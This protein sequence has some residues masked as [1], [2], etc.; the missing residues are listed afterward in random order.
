MKKSYLYLASIAAITVVGIALVWYYNTPHYEQV[1]IARNPGAE[2]ESI[3]DI[4]SKRIDKNMEPLFPDTSI[5]RVVIVT[6]TNGSAIQNNIYPN[7]F[8][9]C[10]ENENNNIHPLGKD[11]NPAIV[12]I[13]DTKPTIISF[14]ASNIEQ[15]RE[16]YLL[17]LREADISDIFDSTSYDNN[18]QGLNFALNTRTIDIPASQ[19][20]NATYAYDREPFTIETINLNITATSEARLG[21]HFFYFDVIEPQRKESGGGFGTMGIPV[22]VEVRR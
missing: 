21:L 3:F 5:K 22:W 6:P 8:G 18:I 7:G 2:S 12:K 19:L 10:S 4:P 9:F 15:T 13:G 1:V 16:L 11:D 17:R 20:L 14:C